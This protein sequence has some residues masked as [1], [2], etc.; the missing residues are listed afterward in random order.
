MALS[1][2]CCR[3][4]ITAQM[5][6]RQRATGK[7]AC[8]I[9]LHKGGRLQACHVMHKASK[10]WHARASSHQQN[11]QYSM[12]DVAA[13]QGLVYPRHPVP[14]S[15]TCLQKA[16]S[17]VNVAHCTPLRTQLQHGMRACHS[18]CC[19]RAS[20]Q[21]TVEFGMPVQPI[22]CAERHMTRQCILQPMWSTT[23]IR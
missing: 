14:F 7:T 5:S 9:R 22:K 12:S 18:A 6:R 16:V 17:C 23:H 10:G 2:N 20:M 1:N 15:S 19:R 4:G 3:A 13:G 21:H 8:L 11:L